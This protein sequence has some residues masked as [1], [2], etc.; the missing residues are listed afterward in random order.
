MMPALVTIV[1]VFSKILKSSR[2]RTRMKKHTIFLL[3]GCF[4][5]LS[6]LGIGAENN[7]KL[8]EEIYEKSKWNLDNLN[9][10]TTQREGKFLT[11]IY[12]KINPDGIKLKTT[13]IDRIDKTGAVGDFID[14]GFLTNETGKYYI[15]NSTAIKM[16]FQYGR[17]NLDTKSLDVSYTLEELIFEK[18]ECYKITRKIELNKESKEI[19][20]KSLPP[21]L[22]NDEKDFLK[23]P[24]LSVVYI[25]KEHSFLI[26]E[27]DYNMNGTPCGEYHIDSFEL[28]PEF[29]G[30]IFVLDKKLKIILAKSIAEYAEITSDIIVNRKKN[31]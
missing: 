4:C 8:A 31:K 5:F 21:E 26:K 11:T 30:G 7:Q 2:K 3:S 10:K 19:Y 9:Y 12:Q 6:L 16:D 27:V 17:K 23:F 28:N 13:I 29:P 14:Q 1:A 18:R 20:I 15:I 25:D 22:Q 24:H